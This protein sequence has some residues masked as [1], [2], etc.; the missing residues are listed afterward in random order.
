MPNPIIKIVNATTGEEI[1]REM[2]KAEMLEFEK[3]KANSELKANLESQAENAKTEL[4]NRLGITEDEA[5]LL[6]S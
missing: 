4:L 5:K 3:L 1:E 2:T 6:L